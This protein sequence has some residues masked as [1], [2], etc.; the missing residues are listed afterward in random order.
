MRF[1]LRKA[2]L[3]SVLCLFIALAGIVLAEGQSDETYGAYPGAPQ[4]VVGQP[5][6]T[7]LVQLG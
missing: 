1:N 2:L 6:Q 7:T 3:P 4:S 5:T